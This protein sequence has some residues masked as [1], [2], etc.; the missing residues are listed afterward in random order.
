LVGQSATLTSVHTQPAPRPRAICTV[1]LENIT[2]DAGKRL[3]LL[4]ELDAVATAALNATTMVHG[5]PRPNPDYNA[6]I[7]A[8]ALAARVCGLDTGAS[9][10]AMRKE[11]A[12]LLANMRAM[13]EQMRKQLQ[14]V[15]LMARGGSTA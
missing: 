5:H 3:L 10:A 9:L 4:R 1:D 14:R 7:A 2:G 6:V 11:Q 12:D 8:L 13:S 15:E